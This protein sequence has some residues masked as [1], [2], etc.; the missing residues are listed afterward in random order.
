MIRV[1][2]LIVST[3]IISWSCGVDDEGASSLPDETEAA[4]L[5]PKTV[6]LSIASKDDLIECAEI[7]QNQLVFVEDEAIFYKCGSEG[8][9]EIDI[10]PKKNLV[11]TEQFITR[12]GS[13]CQYGGTAI[14]SGIDENDDGALSNSERSNTSYICS[15]AEQ[16]VNINKIEADAE[17]ENC[18]LG[19][20]SVE[21]G[22][23][24]NSNGILS[25]NEVSSTEYACNGSA[26]ADGADGTDAVSVV[27]NRLISGD[28]TDY[29]T[30]YNNETCFFTGGNLIKYSDG[31][32]FF[33]ASWRHAFIV[34]GDINTDHNSVS[35]MF[36]AG[37]ESGFI[38]LYHAV[39]YGLSYRSMWIQYTAS[40]DSVELY[41]DTD[42]DGIIDDNE[43]VKTLSFESWGE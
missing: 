28:N 15:D 41:Y 35:A 9:I 21:T 17:N 26:G 39:A 25:S 13:D 34:Y 16:L 27:S 24:T 37:T 11:I 43:K 4:K 30:Y 7:N 33:E 5:E 20:V 3:I 42:D 10:S 36:P 22:L 1:T 12:A 19:G 18:V 29:C 2:L 14:I 23:D 38:L 6:T 8:W 40:T 31:S 32:L